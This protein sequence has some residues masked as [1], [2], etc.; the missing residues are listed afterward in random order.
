MERAVSKMNMVLL[1]GNDPSDVRML[2]VLVYTISADLHR[3][4]TLVLTASTEDEILDI[5]SDH[6]IDI[7][8]AS[9]D[10][11]ALGYELIRWLNSAQLEMKM[12]LVASRS[13]ALPCDGVLQKDG[14]E[15][16]IS[17][18]FDAHQLKSVLEAWSQ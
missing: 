9:Y 2:R 5:L 11:V 8:I 1:A 10:N 7:L 17:R 16:V 18:P 12:F 6:H 15:G 4:P 13:D 3:K 14:V